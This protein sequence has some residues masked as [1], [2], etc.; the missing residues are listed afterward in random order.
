MTK[1]Q[2]YI[3]RLQVNIIHSLNG[4]V[5]LFYTMRP[6]YSTFLHDKIKQFILYYEASLLHL[7]PRQNQAITLYAMQTKYLV[8]SPS[9]VCGPE[10]RY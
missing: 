1:V 8:F 3:P 10:I 5:C 4:P 7:S 6:P 9:S 2:K